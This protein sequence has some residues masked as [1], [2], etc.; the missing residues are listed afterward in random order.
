MPYRKLRVEPP[1]C[2]FQLQLQAGLAR[3]ASGSG[4]PPVP[5]ALR[6]RMQDYVESVLLAENLP[7]KEKNIAMLMQKFSDLVALSE[8]GKPFVYLK[9]HSVSLLFNVCAIQ[10]EMYSDAPDE[11][12]LGYT[13][14][15]MGFLLF[16]PDPHSMG[17]IGL[18]GGS[19]AKYCHRYLPRAAITVAE[20]DPEVIALRA[21]FR[22][23]EESGR[24]RVLCE[25]GAEFVRRAPEGFDVL[26]VDGFDRQGQPPQLCSQRFYDDCHAALAPDGIMVANVLGDVVETE[27]LLDRIHRSFDGAVIVI[28]DADSLNKLVFA[29]KGR[30]LDAPD[31]ILRDRLRQLEA[32]HTVKLESALRRILLARRAG[33]ADGAAPVAQT[34]P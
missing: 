33:I 3:L 31:R 1:P 9:R 19:L 18:G 34:R 11:L 7:P 30:L 20:N 13:Q 22:V 29:C 21:H 6:H 32:S 2:L 26:M 28:D 8:S 17:M 10:S 27:A 16:N 14:A 15:M 24:F 5:A 25:D 23:P 12:V 4:L